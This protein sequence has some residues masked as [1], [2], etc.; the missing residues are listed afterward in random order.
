[1]EACRAWLQPRLCRSGHQRARDATCVEQGA[2]QKSSA[3]ATIVKGLL[4]QLT[5]VFAG[6]QKVIRSV[7]RP[8]P[9]ATTFGS[10]QDAMVHPQAG[11]LQDAATL[12]RRILD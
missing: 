6:A 5:G 8:A 10:I 4:G 3:E 11:R 1:M 9:D 12:Y 2:I 7:P